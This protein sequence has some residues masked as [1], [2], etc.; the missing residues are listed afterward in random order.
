M[1][2]HRNFGLG[3]GLLYRFQITGHHRIHPATKG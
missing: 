1:H 2:K 3:L